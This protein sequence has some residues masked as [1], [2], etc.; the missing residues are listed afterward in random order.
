MQRTVGIRDAKA[1][2]SRLVRLVQAGDSV[3]L[4]RRG[5]PIARI[6]PMDAS[7]TSHEERLDALRQRGWIEEQRAPYVAL[8]IMEVESDLAQR[9]LR[10]DRG[11]T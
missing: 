9:Y 2:L 1:Q 7:D 5:H 6:V 3:T 8:P 11:S 4:T 10:E